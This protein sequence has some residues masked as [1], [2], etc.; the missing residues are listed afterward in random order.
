MHFI[1]SFEQG[2]AEKLLLYFAKACSEDITVVIMSNL[3]DENLKQELLKTGHKAYF[4]DKKKGQKH[5]RY[6]FRLWKVIK[7]NNIDIIHAHDFGSMMWPI[8]CKILKPKLK[9]IYT[10]HSSPD[11]KN[12]NKI[13]LL[14]NRYFIDMNIAISEDILNDCVKNK[15]KAK[16]IY[17]G[18]DIKSWKL[19]QGDT[20]I[21]RIINVARITHQIKGQDILIKALKDC[22]DKGIKFVCDLVGEVNDVK[23]CKYLKT[24]TKDSDLSDEINFL[25]NRED[26]PDLLAQ[27]DLFILPSRIEGLP[28]SLLEAMASR[29]PVIASN[30]SG[31]AELVEHGKNGLLFESENHSDLAEK[32]LFLYNN[33]EEMKRLAENAV[34]SAQRFDISVMVENYWGLYKNLIK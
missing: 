21:F 13:T 17:N 30:I 26:V 15:L 23:S 31:S 1:S 11:V 8:L 2:G 16:K 27:S 32:I 28:L 6:L 24:L 20:R 34:E 4:L 25:E 5:P 9:L 29:L 19:S 12:W 14:I 18:I 3:V 22:K 10:I 33:R 7:D